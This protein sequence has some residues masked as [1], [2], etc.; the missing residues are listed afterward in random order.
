MLPCPTLQASLSHSLCF[1]HVYSTVFKNGFEEQRNVGVKTKGKSDGA[2]LVQNAVP[3]SCAV[4]LVSSSQREMPVT[5]C[6][7][8]LTISSPS[9]RSVGFSEQHCFLVA[10]LQSSQPATLTWPLPSL[11]PR[12]EDFH[13]RC[14]VTLF[15]RSSEW[16]CR[17]QVQVGESCAD[18]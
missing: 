6:A 11:Q 7:Y 8:K 3:C 4:P 13:Q 9:C 5:R 16:C 18:R 10:L 1:C 12:R 14:N 15:L 17:H 2:G